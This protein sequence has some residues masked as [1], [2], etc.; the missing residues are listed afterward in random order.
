MMVAAALCF[1]ACDDGSS[2]KNTGDTLLT[3]PDTP[4]AAI[5]TPADSQLA[6]AWD[7][8]ED[9]TAYEVWYGETNDNA[10]ATE[11]TGDT[12]DTDLSCVITGLD[13]GT[14]YFI[15]LK[16]K[17]TVGTSDFGDVAS[18]TPEAAMEAPDAPGAAVV[19]AGDSQLSLTWTAIN[20]ATAYEVWYSE[21]DDNATATE[22]IGDPDETDL[23]C[24]ITGLTSGIPYYIW[25]RAKNSAGTSGFGDVASGTPEAAMEAPDAPGAAVVT[26]GDSQLSLTW[27]AVD[28]ATWYE[29]WINDENVSATAYLAPDGD[30]VTATSFT[31]EGLVNGTPYYVWIVA[32]NPVGNSDFGEVASGTPDF[33]PAAVSGLAAVTAVDHVTLSWTDPVSFTLDHIEITW[34]PGG[35]GPVSV[36]AGV[37][38]CE[39]TLPADSTARTFTV[40]CVFDDD[41]TFDASIVTTGEAEIYT[42]ADL[43]NVRN[44]PAVHY[45]LMADINL[46]VAPYNTGQGWIP[47]GTETAPYSSCLN[48]NGHRIYNLTINSDELNQGLFGSIGSA[49]WVSNL[50]LETVNVAAGSFIGGLAGKN[51]GTLENCSSSGTV[52]GTG[53]PIGGLVGN[54]SG[55]II[56]CN[57]SCAV[58]GK[59]KAGGLSGCNGG[60]GTIVGSYTSGSVTCDNIKYSGVYIGGIVGD[61]YGYILNCYSVGSV[62][63]TVTIEPDDTVVRRVWA[64]GIAGFCGGT[65]NINYSYA[66]GLITG[67]VIGAG[68]EVF[69]DGIAPGCS[70]VN[71]CYYDSETTH[72]NGGYGEPRT[73]EQMK[74]QSTYAGWDFANVW[75]I[76]TTGAIN[77]GYPY[78]TDNH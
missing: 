5:V 18:G 34:T 29:V 38:T 15:W 9:A 63:G 14:E 58:S 1:G 62:S 52:K 60:D 78:L 61:N 51:K 46:G 59:E 40:T 6:L 41:A 70:N 39:I 17:N 44:N 55:Y 25:L 23:S 30:H 50:R 64:G 56:N 20:G 74:T 12:D 66:A 3:A 45:I 28:G 75:S 53:Y 69:S 49:G 76:D 36:G 4:G 67:T 22:F 24:V 65:S 35:T 10:T 43:D 27:T 73:T 68:G 77:S 7:A 26:A 71:N 8:V 48:G 19:T 33:D 11:Y 13:N 2:G 31:V 47:I 72:Q 16:A 42:A 54:N 57:S 37:E 21:T 32:C